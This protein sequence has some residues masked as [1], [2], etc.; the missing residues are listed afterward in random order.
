M[1][2][3]Y[4]LET[5]RLLLLE[6]L[7]DTHESDD[8]YVHYGSVPEDMVVDPIPIDKYIDICIPREYVSPETILLVYTECNKALSE[9]KWG[10]E[11]EHN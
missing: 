3:E 5:V 8:I 1:E 7:R 6:S 2:E 9:F 4:Y 11:H 10:V